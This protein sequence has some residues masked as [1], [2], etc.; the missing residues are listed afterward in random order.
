MN[1]CSDRRP[2]EKGEA[3]GG[4]HSGGRKRVPRPG[5]GHRP[6]RAQTARPRCPVRGLCRGRLPGLP[7]PGTKRHSPPP[8]ACVLAGSDDG[9]QPRWARAFPVASFLQCLL[10]GPLSNHSRTLGSWRLALS[11]TRDSGGGHDSA[12]TETLGKARRDMARPT[13]VCG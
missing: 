3:S 5:P 10:L 1:T 8:R 11:R 13:G 9:R 6:Q 12:M 7:G 4:T 2:D